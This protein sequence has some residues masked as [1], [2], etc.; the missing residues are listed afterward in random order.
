M[1]PLSLLHRTPLAELPPGTSRILVFPTRAALLANE[2]PCPWEA[3]VVA[4]DRRLARYSAG[5]PLR[6]VADTLAP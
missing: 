3:Y 5:G 6:W 4:E 2:P 1:L